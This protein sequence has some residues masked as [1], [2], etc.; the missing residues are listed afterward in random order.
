MRK[1]LNVFME[2]KGVESEDLFNNGVLI[3]WP[4]TFAKKTFVLKLRF[5]EAFLSDRYQ[6]H[7][8][9]G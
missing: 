9:R 2:I 1:E 4:T 3:L 7:V 6:R 5:A 8:L